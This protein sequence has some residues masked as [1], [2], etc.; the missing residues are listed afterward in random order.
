MFFVLK[1]LIAAVVIIAVLQVKVGSD[2]LESHAE[3]WVKTSEA[4]LQLRHVASGAIKVS[5]DLWK[6]ALGWAESK[7][8]KSSSKKEWN[9]EFRRK[10]VK[11][12]SE[13]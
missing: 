6:K 8:A 12:D 9:V 11:D 1:S 4:S 3:R 2:T 7:P 10:I 5:G 13:E